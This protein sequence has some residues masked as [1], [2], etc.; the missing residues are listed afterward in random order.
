MVSCS[1]IGSAF[2][3]LYIHRIM[4]PLRLDDRHLWLEDIDS[5]LLSSRHPSPPGAQHAHGFGRGVALTHFHCTLG[6]PTW[7]QHV[8]LG[9]S[10]SLH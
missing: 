5:T 10:R 4:V 9:I 6:L 1:E 2:I 8:S 7:F 3:F